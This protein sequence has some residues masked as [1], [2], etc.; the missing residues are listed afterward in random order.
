MLSEISVFS[1]ASDLRDALGLLAA[2]A[3]GLPRDVERSF[4]EFATTLTTPDGL[5]ALQRFG[6][7]HD[8]PELTALNLNVLER[9]FD[10][11][12]LADRARALHGARDVYGQTKLRLWQL[13][14]EPARDALIPNPTTVE[15]LR[16]LVALDTS[17]DGSGVECCLELLGDWLTEARFDVTV[18]RE[19][20]ARPIIVARRAA[21]GG[22]QGRIAL[23]GHYD[24]DDR[25]DEQWSTPPLELTEVRGRLFG[26]GV[27]DNKAPL[28]LRI[29]VFRDL[30]AC[31]ELFWV[32]QGEEETGSPF[33]HRRLPH[34]IA[35]ERATLWL[36]ENGYHDPDGT[37]RFL[38][39][40]INDPAD[41]TTVQPP[42]N[43]LETMLESLGA[44]G[45]R[46]GVR[47]RL[48]VRSL[49][50]SFFAEGCPWGRN[51]PPG[52]RYLAVGLNDPA[53]RIHKPDESVPM[54]TF[55]LHAHQLRELTRLVHSAAVN[56]A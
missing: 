11:V 4:D 45:S 42:D 44:I 32:I 35:D 20:N 31:P 50:K 47:H 25:R 3:C 49:N 43:V 53:S 7:E 24:V 15:R 12:L 23:Y 14:W 38:A 41:A 6:G 9:A 30:D 13:L 19:P 40:I 17:P 33:A 21:E 8:I 46:F 52:A 55:P 54:W 37:Q 2:T 5:A 28:S 29:E 34:L 16:E 26:L 48:E 36:E 27:G 22:M 10:D 1:A 39:R 51:L 56:D 18:I